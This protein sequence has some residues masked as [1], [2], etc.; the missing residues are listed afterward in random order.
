M[1]IIPH[2]PVSPVG[3]G[4]VVR[5][6]AQA[7]TIKDIVDVT[8]PDAQIVGDLRHRMTTKVHLQNGLEEIMILRPGSAPDMVRGKSGLSGK[9][10]VLGLVERGGK[11]RTVIRLTRRWTN[12]WRR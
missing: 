3:D 10:A 1:A 4:H 11:V 12:I 9:R 2:D 8:L 6:G 5:I 7:A